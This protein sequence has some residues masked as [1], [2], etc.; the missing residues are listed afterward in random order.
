M[1]VAAARRAVKLTR[2]L[3]FSAGRHGLRYGV[4]AAVEHR[5]ALAGL[6]VATIVDIGSNKGQFALLAIEVFPRATIFCFEPLKEPAARLREMLGAEITLFETAIGPCEK[7]GIINVSKRCD[8]SSLLP[9]AKQAEVF[10]GTEMKEQRVVPI[11]PLLQY[12]SPE[13]IQS[14]ALLKIDVQGYELEVLKGCEPLLACFR[15]VY[16]E[17]SFVELYQGQALAGDVILY[18]IDRNFELSGVYGQVEDANRRPVQAD[19]LFTNTHYKRT[20]Q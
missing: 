1:L 11:V 12:L 16:S 9:F 2:L 19:F 8:S 6:D 13:N 18:L 20:A 3:T 10:P 5:R 15:Y 4:G 14:P 17:C 7:E